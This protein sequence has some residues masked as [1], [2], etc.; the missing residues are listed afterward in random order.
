VENAEGRSNEGKRNSETENC[1][2]E[3]D[4]ANDNY[5]IGYRIFTSGDSTSN[6]SEM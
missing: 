5:V 2:E 3:K 6:L 1:A 4:E